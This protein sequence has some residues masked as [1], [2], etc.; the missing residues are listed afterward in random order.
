L[1]NH[2]S[3]PQVWKAS[4][5]AI[6]ETVVGTLL[7]QVGRYVSGTLKKK[8][9]PRHKLANRLKV[10]YESLEECQDAYNKWHKKRTAKTRA[11]YSASVRA[12]VESVEQV[13]SII[14]IYDDKAADSLR[15]YVGGEEEEEN[16]WED[17]NEEEDED[18]GSSWIQPASAVA[19]A[20]EGLNQATLAGNEVEDD[21]FKQARNLLR[22][23]IKM[24]DLV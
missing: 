4:D 20:R 6:W 7:G 8:T 5:V 1:V 14:S 2:F 16:D 12:L 22:K 17:G 18:S 11:H 13:D 9:A 19:R 3:D 23:F 15:I 21:D 10:L 24:D